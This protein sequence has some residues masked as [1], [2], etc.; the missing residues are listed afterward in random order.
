[1][2]A[3]WAR[4]QD[5]V[6][7]AQ[8]LRY[9]VF[10]LELGAR[11]DGPLPGH[12]VDRFDEFCDHLLVRPA[13]GGPVIGTYRLLTPS[14]A[15]RAGGGYSDEEF[16][17]AA[18]SGLRPRMAELG[19]SCVSAEHRRGAVILGL[20]GAV[21]S[22]LDL[23]RLEGLIGCVSIGAGATAVGTWNNVRR[24]HL[25][26][27]PWEARPRVPMPL[28]GLQDQLDD[29]P[30]LLR[31]YLRIGAR[32]LGP[33]AWDARFGGADLPVMLHTRDLPARFRGA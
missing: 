14:Q 19:R 4:H 26:Q 33:P 10:A 28:D 8:R 13:P 29:P 30:P 1:M 12:D 27:P 11:I 16:D 21:A 25:A 22:F 23:Q 17:L 24:R 18:L 6:R 15:R 20:W 7:E 3:S 2:H 31:T 32:V 5:E 9:R